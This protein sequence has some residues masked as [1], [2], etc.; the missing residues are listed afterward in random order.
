VVIIRTE[1]G[2]RPRF[3][4]NAHARCGVE[5]EMGEHPVG[6]GIESRILVLRGQR[7]KLYRVEVKAL[8]QAV[9]RNAERF[10][11]DF[12]FQ[13]SSQEIE[14]LRSQFVTLKTG[15]RRGR[16]AKYPPHAFTEQGVAM[17]SSVLKSKAAVS[18]NI[19]IM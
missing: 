15:G 12:M 10:P 19:E 7:A 5:P 4:V 1:S 14:S 3:A 16:H 13:L 2:G 11:G 18:V 8:N 17:L 6:P 9:K